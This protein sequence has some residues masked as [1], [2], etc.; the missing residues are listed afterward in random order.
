MDKNLHIVIQIWV[1]WIAVL[2][3]SGA[4]GQNLFPNPDFENY[5]TCPLG[6]DQLSGLSDWSAGNAATPDYFNCSFYG[7]ST[8]GLP[9]SG[10]GVVGLWGGA[11]HPDCTTSGF[12]EN[13][14]ATL[15]S[16]L[17][18]G[19]LYDLAF[20]LQI[21]DLGWLSNSPNECMGVGFYFYESTNPPILT[22]TCCPAVNPQVLIPAL[23]IQKGNYIRF[24]SSILALGNWDRVL[25][26]V[27]CTPQTNSTNCLSYASNK[28]YFNIDNLSLTKAS[29]L[30][31]ET[32]VSP[33]EA[34]APDQL[35]AELFPNPTSTQAN[36]QVDL[37]TSG[38]VSVSCVDMAGQ[39]IWDK[40]FELNKGENHIGLNA[41]E[42]SK[43][44]YIIRLIEQ[45]TG[46]QLYFRWII[47]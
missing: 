8:Q 17:I 39:K 33:I 24:S 11:N 10:S 1:I 44:M 9:S 23:A 45:R 25:V 29:I 38:W 2:C 15:N 30:E 40:G 32:E 46:K 21:D 5:T 35:F 36:I 6:Y 16:K 7:S 26:G 19:D 34:Y 43:G 22:G 31:L 27:F 3:S 41:N 18:S 37:P 28:M 13:I 14:T 12:A 47:Q 42:L 4:Y 20:D